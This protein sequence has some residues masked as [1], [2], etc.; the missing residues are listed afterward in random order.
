MQSH[1]WLKEKPKDF[2][3][4]NSVFGQSFEIE[5]ST[6]QWWS[7]E[8]FRPESVIRKKLYV[9]WYVVTYS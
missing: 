3:L 4:G 5:R 8:I 1:A 9:S 7:L 2:P 6:Y